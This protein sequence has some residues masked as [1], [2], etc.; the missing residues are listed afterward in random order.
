MEYDSYG[1]G[2][3]A[4]DAGDFIVGNIGEQSQHHDGP[5]PM[6]EARKRIV[7]LHEVIGELRFNHDHSVQRPALGG[8][9]TML[10]V[11]G[12]YDGPVQVRLGALDARQSW[13]TGQPRILNGILCVLLRSREQ[14]GAPQ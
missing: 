2:P 3:T 7:E 10:A 12:I 9:S 4:E 1:H 13:S 8:P 5:C 11:A 14:P 6:T